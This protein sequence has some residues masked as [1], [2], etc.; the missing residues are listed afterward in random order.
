MNSTKIILL[1]LWL[2]LFSGC[3]L[4][5]V[6]HPTQN[7]IETNADK[8]ARMIVDLNESIDP[9]EAQ[10]FAWESLNYAQRLAQDYEV[11]APALWH[12]TLVNIGVKKRGLCYQWAEDMLDHLLRQNYQT[13]QLYVVGSDIGNYFEHNALV[14]TGIGESYRDGIVLDAWRNSGDLF[15]VHLT[16]DKKYE[17][18]NRQILY[19]A[20]LFRMY[21]H[22]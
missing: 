22:Y 9:N 13:I 19:Q 15:F 12:N 1:G 5:P 21:H 7:E 4:M 14:V 2:L 17:W 8:L 18:K 16:E 6:P 10:K 20:V 3:S 11:V